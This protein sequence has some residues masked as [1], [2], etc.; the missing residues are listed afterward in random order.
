MKMADQLNAR[1]PMTIDQDTRLDNI[2]AGPGT[3]ITYNYTIVT[4]SS[5]EVDRAALMNHLKTTLKSGVCSHP[6]MQVFFKNKVTVGYSYRAS[7]G[8]FVGKLNITPR[9]CG[10]AS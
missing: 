7:D 5:R 2:L 1:M 8:P 9:D 3:R 6:D 4:A 10:Y